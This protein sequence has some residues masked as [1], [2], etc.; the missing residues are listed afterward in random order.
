ME[1]P[2][3]NPEHYRFARLGD[4]QPGKRVVII[5]IDHD[6]PHPLFV[7]WLGQQWVEVTEIVGDEFRYDKGQSRAPLSWVSEPL[8]GMAAYFVPLDGN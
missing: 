4:V 7:P 5:D 1:V 8:S 6:N 3:D 2:S